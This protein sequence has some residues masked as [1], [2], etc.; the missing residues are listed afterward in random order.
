MG[1]TGVST[2]LYKAAPALWQQMAREALRPIFPAPFRPQPQRWPD[3]GLYATWLGHSTVLLRLD[4]FTILTDPIFS[5]RA[6]L[7]L[8]PLTLGLK[9]LVAPALGMRQLPRID[10]VLVSHAHMDHLDVPSLR[11]LESRSTSLVMSWKTSD[12]VHAG[13][14]REVHE[15]AWGQ[16]AR[17]GPVLCRAFEVKHW[18]ARYRNDTYRGY[19]GYIIE[20]GPYRVLFAGDTALTGSFRKLRSTRG[21]D[22]AIMPIGA[23]NPW[24][25]NHCTPEQAWSMSND[26]GAEFLLP[27][28]HQTF[29]LS[30]EPALEPI[31][32]LY[33]AAGNQDDRVVIEKIGEEFRLG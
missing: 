20:A 5:N 23:Y 28:H 18:G 21:F 24:I 16:T 4:G 1:L 33:D 14:Y 26:A 3:K 29:R 32:R 27:V 7:N 12:L 2:Y 11:R 17:V 8:G 13:R 22:L 15:L 31:A 25:R 30:Q 19:N 10:L 6:G 9:R